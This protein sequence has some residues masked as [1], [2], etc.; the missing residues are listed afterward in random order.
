[1][2]IYIFYFMYQYVFDMTVTYLIAHAYMDRH[3]MRRTC[4]S[5]GI[6]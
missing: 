6:G 5:R 1:M 3:M 2:I 4:K